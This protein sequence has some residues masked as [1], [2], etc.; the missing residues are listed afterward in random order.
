MSSKNI[1]HLVTLSILI[2]AVF[3][4][5]PA[6]ARTDV[7][8]LPATATITGQT[9]PSWPGITPEIEQSGQTSVL[10]SIEIDQNQPSGP[11]YMAHFDQGDLAQ[12]FMQSY[13]NIAGAGI[14]LQAGIGSTD[15]VTIQ[16]WDALPNAGGTMLT[17]A[18]VTGTA[19]S[20]VDVFW[21]AFPVTPMTT[22]YLVFVG[23]T[24]LGIAGD[25]NNP[26]PY[27]NVFA[28]PGFNPFAGFDYAF[29]TY[30]DTEVPIERHT[31]A[32]V[33]ALFD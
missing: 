21:T 24:T 9:W 4:T 11:A 27:G 28:N 31:W 23:N 18:T 5:S 29:R 1:L 17:E 26:Y 30:Y 25:L 10:L 14:L 33:K 13:D 3:V 16:L 20:W 32:N 7:I 22:Y 8:G 6:H 12:S 19:G 15:D 2:A